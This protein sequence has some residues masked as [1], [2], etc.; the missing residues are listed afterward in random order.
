MRIAKR[1]G[2]ILAVAASALVATSQLSNAQIVLPADANTTCAISQAEFNSWFQT[3]S[4]TANGIVDHADSLAFVPTSDC[5][6][7]K[8]SAQMFLW[9]TSPAP[10]KY[11]PGSHV[12]NSPVFYDVMPRDPQTHQRTLRPNA[13][14]KSKT[15]SVSISQLG[16]QGKPVVFDKTGKM[17]TIVRPEV[18]PSGKPLIRNKAGA[19][20]EIERTQIAPGGKP[21]FLDKS[22]QAIDLS[23]TRRGNLRLMDRSGRPIELLPTRVSINGKL[24]FRDSQGNLVEIEQ[25]QADNSVLMA[26]NSSLVYYA[27]QVNDVFAY[28]HSGQQNGAIKPPFTKF[29]TRATELD[30]IKA[31][32]LAHGKTFPDANALAV[33]VKS[34]WIEMTPDLDASKYVTMTATVPT[35]KKESSTLWVPESTKEVQLALVGMHVVGSTAGHPEMIWAT[36]E[37]V[38]N[39]PNDQYVYLDRTNAVKT[40]P[41]TTTGTWLFSASGA[42]GPSESRRII[43]SDS[44]IMAVAG[45]E[46]GP[47]N[48]IRQNAWGTLLGNNNA[49]VNNTRVISVNKS[50]I[51]KLVGDDVRRNYIMIGATW[52]KD[53]AP[54]SDDQ[55]F[56]APSNHLGTS[57][58]ANTTMETFDQ[59]SNCFSCHR[60]NML[61]TA[62]SRGLSHIYGELKPLLP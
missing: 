14:G 48:I 54:P 20:I 43:L 40:A 37:H 36:F 24:F 34:A 7:Y 13:P 55:D 47:S 21:T 15:L 8:W 51:D 44:K 29:P 19:P 35:Y 62:G 42:S 10:T 17:F 57:T 53:G 26:Q 58:L 52:T 39:T 23:P 46:I 5:S 6:F 30:K 9:L 56:D 32:A 16:P 27:M 41:R 4:A 33:E 31:F 11:G 3:G 25:G 18:G 22:G 50:V 2:R 12:F 45:A 59:M 61:G 1:L 49:A 28:F 60:G 38:S